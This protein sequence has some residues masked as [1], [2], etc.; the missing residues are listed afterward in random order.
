MKTRQRDPVGLVL[1]TMPADSEF[2]RPAEGH[3]A[4]TAKVSLDLLEEV[5]GRR[6][7][8]TDEQYQQLVE[9]LANNPLATPVTV[10][11]I[12]H[13]RFEIIA[14]HNRVTAYR[15]LERTE[16]DVHVV[17]LDDDGVERAAFYS[18]L[19]SVNLPDYQKYLGFKERMAS[20]GKNQSEIAEEA[21]INRSLI[22][23]LM[24]FG[25][26]PSAALNVVE[27][28]PEKFG[29]AGIFEVS[30][31]VEHHPADVIAQALKQVASEE[32]S[33]KQAISLIKSAGKGKAREKPVPEIITIRRGNT[34]FCSVRKT[35]SSLRLD[36]SDESATDALKEE[37]ENLIKK[38]AKAAE[39]RV[40]T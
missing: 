20:T 33:M 28:N 17:D 37:I 11:A 18:N 5:P 23:R 6:R 36:F 26:L 8:L 16:I 27:L 30:K 14:G 34:T 3:P 2:G 25:T 10:R 35:G 38:Y 4:V 32:I 19:L 15:E 39:G 1:R 29:L 9:N 13:G 24:A 12:D 40:S 21:G 31:L 22:S 7:K